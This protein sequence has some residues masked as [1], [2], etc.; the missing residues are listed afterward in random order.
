ML[1]RS[2]RYNQAKSERLWT[3]VFSD[4]DDD[5]NDDDDDDDNN[6]DDSDDEDTR[7]WVQYIQKVAKTIQVLTLRQNLLLH[8]NHVDQLTAH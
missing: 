5:D 1:S 3:R 6:D 7:G 4:K 8:R 2:R